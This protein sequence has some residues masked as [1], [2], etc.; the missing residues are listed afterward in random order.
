MLCHAVPCHAMPGLSV[1]GTTEYL[2]RLA[3]LYPRQVHVHRKSSTRGKAVAAATAAAAAAA[4]AA[5]T[6]GGRGASGNGDGHRQ[7]TITAD[8]TDTGTAVF[9]QDK[10]EMVGAT[11]TSIDAPCVMMQ[12]DA[13]ELWTGE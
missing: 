13:D 1:D 7:D 9:W 5:Q 12:L 10:L 3:A 2:D 4:A 11:A 6:E 8:R